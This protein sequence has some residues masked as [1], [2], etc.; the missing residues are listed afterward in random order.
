MEVGFNLRFNQ[1]IVAILALAY[2]S[3]LII[4]YGTTVPVVYNAVWRSKKYATFPV[5]G[6]LVGLCFCV[7]G[8]LWNGS[9]LVREVI[10][11]AGI[12]AIIGGAPFITFICLMLA[13]NPVLVKIRNAAAISF[14]SAS[15]ILLCFV[16]DVLGLKFG[17]VSGIR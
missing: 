12:I 3:G 16:W 13:Q 9:T 17:I 5:L 4:F 10:I 6:A 2:F 15:L 7:L 1:L 8:F 11:P 14:G